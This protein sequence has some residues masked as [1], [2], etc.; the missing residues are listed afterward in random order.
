MQVR[1]T[2]SSGSFSNPTPTEPNLKKTSTE[3]KTSFVC[4]QKLV[5]YAAVAGAFVDSSAPGLGFAAS[6]PIFIAISQGYICPT[7]ITTPQNTPIA[8][9]VINSNEG[10]K[11][12]EEATTYTEKQ[13]DTA[14]AEKKTKPEEKATTSIQ[15]QKDTAAATDAA[16]FLEGF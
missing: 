7:P 10:A 14:A 12:Q 4:N 1:N 5:S 6:L 11:T 9:P 2:S 13:K 3:E 16:A 8:A 15:K